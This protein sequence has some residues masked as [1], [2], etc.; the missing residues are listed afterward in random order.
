[1]HNKALE[2]NTLEKVRIKNKRIVSQVRRQ[3]SRS[4]PPTEV[5]RNTEGKKGLKVEGPAKPGMQT[6]LAGGDH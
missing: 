5:P 4:E 6:V 2:K 1:M 3:G